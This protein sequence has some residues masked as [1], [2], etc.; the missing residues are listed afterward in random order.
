MND[1]EAKA[2]QEVAKTSSDALRVAEKA[3]S[4][5]SKYVDGT[6]Q[7]LAGILEDKL[8]YYRWE[9]RNRLLIRAEKFISEQI[10]S[11]SISPVP[12]KLTI[13]IL[14]AG[15]VEED[16]DV[17][18]IYAQ[19]LAN[20]ANSSFEVRIERTYIDI[21]QNLSKVEIEILRELY[22]LDFDTTWKKG[23]YSTHLPEKLCIEK[24]DQDNLHPLPKIEIALSNLYR[25]QLINRSTTWG[26][27]EILSHISPTLFGKAFVEACGLITSRSEPVHE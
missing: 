27:T 12:L 10:D 26:G 24:P 17:Q 21:L 18:D 15:S 20:A 25:F 23:V 14:E 13:P 19:L 16:D 5:L 2:I 3:G 22:K 7:Q 8:K 4:F 1:E 11:S 9:R 6:F